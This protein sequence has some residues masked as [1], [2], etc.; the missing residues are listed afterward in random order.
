MNA[1]EIVARLEKMRGQ[2]PTMVQG[3]L[4][5]LIGDVTRSAELALYRSRL[6]DDR[7]V[8]CNTTTLSICDIRAW[9]VA[10]PPHL[11]YPEVNGPI[12]YVWLRDVRDAF[13][14]RGDFSEKLSAAVEG[15][16]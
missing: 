4:A 9:S 8:T 12:T 11:A 2:D 15:Q 6:H 7:T 16:P 1:G 3:S 14:L 13:V 5:I 10:S